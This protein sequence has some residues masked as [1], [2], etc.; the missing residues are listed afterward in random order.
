MNWRSLVALAQ[1]HTI[2][3]GISGALLVT[4]LLTTISMA[5]YVSSGASRLDLSRPGYEGVRETVQR[6]ASEVTFSSTGS[7]DT[8]VAK[9]FQKRFSER[10]T[11]LGKLG[12]YGSNALDDDQLQI[13][14]SSDAQ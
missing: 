3:Y 12:N 14:P 2:I 9:D 7:L 6:D 11:Q 4:I 1:R 10:R 8:D 5:L 13:A